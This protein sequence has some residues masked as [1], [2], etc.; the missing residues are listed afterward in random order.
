MLCSI[1]FSLYR[2]SILLMSFSPPE[3]ATTSIT[4][5]LMHN[6]KFL[7]DIYVADL[8]C[9]MGDTCMDETMC[10]EETLICMHG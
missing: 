4:L 2:V 3:V 9:I 5:L 1:Y 6:K 8:Y 10:M 7:A